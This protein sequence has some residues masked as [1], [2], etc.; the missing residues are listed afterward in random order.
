M[1][2]KSKI[3]WCDETW[4]PLVGCKAVSPGCDN[5]YAAREASGRLSGLPLYSGLA[6]SGKFTGEVRLVRERLSQ[7]L[8][9]QRPRRIFVNSMSDL[10]H[11]SVPDS[12]I[13]EV[14]AVLAKADRHV[15]QV[16]TKRP[17]RMKTWCGAN[18]PE[19]LANVWLGTSIEA[20]KYAFRADQLRATPAAVRFLSCEPL[21]GPLPSLDLAGIDWA[22]A[23]G[24][25]GPNARPMHPDWVRDL[26]D[27]CLADGVAFLF[28]QWGEWHPMPI[29]DANMMTGR[30]FKVPGGTVAARPGNYGKYHW[31]DDETMA[32]KV[33]KK[34]AGRKLDGMVWDQYPTHRPVPAGRAFGAASAADGK[35]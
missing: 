29:F 14:F 6:V 19:A 34:V 28:K 25:S 1:S 16:L 15:F 31:L 12:F 10:F 24:E 13:R 23:G 30:A 32:V 4:N 22:I 26:R 17:Q 8:K 18:Y 33:G 20:D 5:C 3:E 9:W 7:P 11:A 2:G 35:K 21:L 27:R